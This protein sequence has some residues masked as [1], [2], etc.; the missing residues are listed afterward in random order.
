MSNKQKEVELFTYVKPN[1]T[2]IEINA[3]SIAHAEK[4]GWKP[5]KEA[6][7]KKEG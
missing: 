6:K 4:L 3:N 7:P 1:N 5:K 2:E